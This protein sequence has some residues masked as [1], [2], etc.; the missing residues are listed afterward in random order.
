MT[1]LKIN[2]ELLCNSTQ[3]QFV[4]KSSN[5]KI[6]KIPCTNS[7]RSTC[8]DSCPLKN[9]GSCYA[10]SGFYT[11]LNW[12]KVDSKERGGTW[13]QLCDNIKKLKNGQL[14]RHNVSGDL[15]HI[16]QKID[17]NKMYDLTCANMDKK[18]FTYTHH[19]VLENNDIAKHNKS[20]IDACNKN[21][22]TVN[23]S[24]NN[25]YHAIQLKALNIA[26]VVSIVP[27]DQLTN[28]TLNGVKFVICPAAIRNNV[29]CEKCNMCQLTDRDFTI[30]FP[31]HGGGKNKIKFP[32]H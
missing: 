22:F 25:P 20:I 14:W 19:E 23:L 2:T 29:D 31:A 7:E 28:F 24:G 8:P 18:G 21:G 3:V 27:I 17:T 11:R 13:S 5:V 12:D 9:D 1:N 26:P 4:K 6:G 30:A 32:T 10:E 15:P 16:D